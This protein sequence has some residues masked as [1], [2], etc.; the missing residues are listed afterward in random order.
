[1]PT[2]VGTRTLRGYRE[3]ALTISH[4]HDLHL[5]FLYF[6]KKPRKTEKKRKKPVF[7]FKIA[8]SLQILHL[9][10]I[11]RVKER[12]DHFLGINFLSELNYFFVANFPFIFSFFKLVGTF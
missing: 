6:G 4:S 2:N 8:F 1:M 5:Y 12:T 7:S 3:R 10:I 11:G 9:P